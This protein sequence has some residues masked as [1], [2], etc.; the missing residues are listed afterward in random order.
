M[1]RENW[2]KMLG[3]IPR[4]LKSM[5]AAYTTYTDAPAT[6]TLIDPREK[7]VEAQKRLKWAREQL[8]EAK[9]TG[10]TEQI[11]H[12]IWTEKAHR[13]EINK[14]EGRIKKL[15]NKADKWNKDNPDKEKKTIDALL[16]PAAAAAVPDYIREHHKA[17]EKVLADINEVMKKATEEEDTPYG[18]GYQ[19]YTRG[20]GEA[21]D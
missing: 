11:N 8:K 15:Q 17:L 10:D 12:W 1:A 9:E 2:D 5:I 3:H 20:S 4:N 14:H 19:Y 21:A 16:V 7:K 18:H 6:K 13:Q